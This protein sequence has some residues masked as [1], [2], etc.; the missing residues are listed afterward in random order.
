MSIRDEAVGAG[1]TAILSRP[2][3]AAG[4]V[5]GEAEA[6]ARVAIDAALAV[7]QPTVPNDVAALDALPVGTV[8]RSGEYLARRMRPGYWAYTDGFMVT[9]RLAYAL[10]PTVTEWT[11]IYQ[12]EE[13]R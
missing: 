6:D 3:D 4:S 9:T 5:A 1:A 7:L 13:D 12:P 2:I 10:A 11:V 8:L